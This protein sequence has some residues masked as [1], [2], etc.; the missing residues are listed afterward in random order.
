MVCHY[1][2]LYLNCLLLSAN[3]LLE[4]N[5]WYVQFPHGYWLYEKSKHLW[6]SGYPIKAKLFKTPQ[7]FGLHLIW[8]LSTSQN[9]ADCSCVHCNIPSAAALNKMTNSLED[10]LIITPSEKIPV[11]KVTPV[12]LP[13][14][15]GQIGAK[16]SR[17]PMKPPTPVP[18]QASPQGSPKATKTQS[19]A[20]PKAL[21]P[22]QTTPVPLPHQGLPVPS[23]TPVPIPS[24]EPLPLTLSSPLIFR[25]GELVW[26][27]TG[28]AWRLGI[29]SNQL[30]GRH[31][32]VQLGY[33]MI[34]LPDTEK[35][36]AEMRPFH[37]FSVPPASLPE[38]SGRTYDEVRF[39]ALFQ[40]LGPTGNRDMAL[41]DASKLA[42]TKID[43][44][45]SLWSTKPPGTDSVIRYHGM[46]LGAERLEL[47]DCVR[48]DPA[49]ML[50]T[51]N[52]DFTVAVNPFGV[53]AIQ[54]LF[55]SSTAYPP[56]VFLQGPAYAPIPPN[57]NTPP[58]PDDQ[59]PLAL[60]D[61]LLWKRQINPAQA[62]RYAIINRELSIKASSIKGR[63]YP[64]QRLLQILDPGRL[65]AA[66]ANGQVD[67][68]Y[69][70]FNSRPPLVA[71]RRTRLETFGTSVPQSMRLSLEAFI[72][73]D[74]A[75]FEGV[76]A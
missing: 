50:A 16:A 21:P 51:A 57:S 29:I 66:M 17:S 69:A 19:R 28:S 32:I 37:A 22:S 67:N 40:Q 48:I 61:E 26:V 23:P 76:P 13:P 65:Q 39:D 42:A 55:I 49:Q 73:E 18:T 62:P 14:M 45:Q 56:T 47:G 5:A 1:V 31:E 9:R 59:L 30:N 44:S 15:P 75:V 20:K 68:L 12:P 3:Q 43:Q 54:K 71:T 72:R 63:F 4:G 46:F 41:L 10:T 27:Q 70:H 11:P 7:E 60:R 6:V 35:G 58:V 24:I 64:V 38:L 74:S 2:F 8:L 34:P 33:K 53:M 52:L 36:D 25:V